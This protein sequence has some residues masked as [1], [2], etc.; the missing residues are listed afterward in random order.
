M[1]L[2]S[3]LPRIASTDPF[4]CS[5]AYLH[6]PHRF[7]TQSGA[8][9]SP[10]MP[11]TYVHTVLRVQYTRQHDESSFSAGNLVLSAAKQKS[12]ALRTPL[13]LWTT[14]STLPSRA[15]THEASGG[16]GVEQR[17]LSLASPPSLY[18]RRPTKSIG[19]YGQLLVCIRLS[20]ARTHQQQGRGMQE[21][22]KRCAYPR[23]T[24]MGDRVG[25][26]AVL[27]L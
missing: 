11:C 15:P 18:R 13:W 10:V 5:G 27:C 17:R 20:L 21:R 1:T 9:F 3:L 22:V 25:R 7:C 19:K 26:D 16:F 24:S 12:V 4:M 2:R 14:L 23:I 6:I 8:A